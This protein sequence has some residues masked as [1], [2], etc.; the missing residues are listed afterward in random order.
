MNREILF[1]AKRI[2]WRDLPKEQWWIEG[3]YISGMKL[4]GYDGIQDFI[5]EKMEITMQLTQT[6]S[7][8]TQDLQTRTFGRMIL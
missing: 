2:D 7:A 8:S 4:P 5:I 1:K 3:H 6:P